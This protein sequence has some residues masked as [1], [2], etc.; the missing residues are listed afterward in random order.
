MIYKKIIKLGQLPIELY[1]LHQK[2]KIVTFKSKDFNLSINNIRIKSNVAEINDSLYYFGNT[3][4]NV[5]SYKKVKNL[6]ELKLFCF[7]ISELMD[8]LLKGRVTDVSYLNVSDLMHNDTIAERLLTLEDAVVPDYIVQLYDVLDFTITIDD[9]RGIISSIDDNIQIERVSS[10][11]IKSLFK[12]EYLNSLYMI[13]LSHGRDLDISGIMNLIPQLE[14][15]KML[16]IVDM[17]NNKQ[18]L[19][20]Y[21]HI[22]EY[23]IPKLF[24]YKIK[25]RTIEVRLEDLTDIFKSKLI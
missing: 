4:N 14:S 11:D 9:D 24:Q 1:D 17:H 18:R 10:F 8:L 13:K 19:T 16:D 12:M 21:L 3:Y 7:H 25:R 23:M 5:N 22:P 15:K 20:I 6:N 2:C